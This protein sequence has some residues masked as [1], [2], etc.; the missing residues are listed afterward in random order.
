MK[1]LISIAGNGK[2]TDGST[3]CAEFREL[4]A[5][6]PAERLVQYA[7]E[8]LKD[9]FQD[10]GLALQD[11]INEVGRR[12][13][14]GVT[15][16]RYRGR[17]GSIGNDGLWEL[18]NRHKIVVEVKTTDAYRI[19]LNIIAAY[20]RDLVQQGAT[21]DDTSSV[22]IVVGRTDTGDL[23]AQIRGSRHAWEMRLISVDALVRL[24]LLKQS[25][26]DPDALRR[27]YEILI[28]REFTKLDEIVELVFS[29][30][31]DAKQIEDVPETE[32][33]HQH[34]ESVKATEPKF[35]PVAFNALIAER[36]ARHLGTPLLKRTRALF[37]SPDE[38]IR[39]VC[40]ASRTYTGKSWQGYW[41]AIHPHQKEALEGAQRGYA[42]FG[43]G[44]PAN[45]F[46]IP[47]ADFAGW[48]DGMNMT[49]KEDRP[50][51]HVQIY[52]EDGNPTLVRKKGT[53]RIDLTQY[54]ISG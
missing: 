22:L 46:L 5:E 33:E 31:E 39:V 37:S 34:V 40:A 19:D 28:P 10:S 11:I 38:S 9:G 21:T 54:R 32:D 24:M 29:T 30:A 42:A 47:L 45:T 49:L 53:P 6:V 8:C 18:P 35:T 48:L 26:D 23:E 50:Y 15:Y 1:Q 14:F 43:C 20:R 36:V 4:L 41:F 17:T 27:I 2:L 44:S 12:L 13:G 52:E 3:T 7:D 16:G 25:V 51:W